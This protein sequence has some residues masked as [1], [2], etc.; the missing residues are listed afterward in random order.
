MSE[1]RLDPGLKLLYRIQSAAMSG[2]RVAA[3]QA[4][5]RS[6]AAEIVERLRTSAD[7]RTQPS[8]R[9]LLLLHY[10]GDERRLADLGFDMQARIGSVY[11]GVLDLEHL[12]ELAD[13]PGLVSAELSRPLRGLASGEPVSPGIYPGSFHASGSPLPSGIAAGTGVVVGLVD[14]G[15]DIRHRTFRNANGTTRIKYLLDLSNPGDVDGDGRLDGPDEF[16]GTLYTEAQINR[17]LASSNPPPTHDPTGHGTLA[18]S[19]AAGS[20]SKYPGFA[21]GAQLVVVKATRRDGTLDFESADLLSA[22]SFID[23]KAA[24]LHL[25]YVINMSLGTS[26]GPHDGKTAEEVAIDELVGPGIAGKA[27][28][29]AAGNSDQ[30]GTPSFRHFQGTAFTGLEV[31]HT[32]TIPRYATPTPGVGN[33]TALL[34]LWYEGSDRLTIRV[35]A[36]DGATTVTAAYGDFADTPTPFGQVFIGN[37]GGPDPRNGATEAVVLLYDESGMAPAAGDWTISVVGE[38]ISA[39]GIYHGWLVDGASLV[40]GVA[41]Y[42]SANADNNYLVA[43]PAAAENAI[44][45][46]SFARQDPASLFRTHWTDIKGTSHTDGGARTG[47][48][49]NFSSTGPTRDGRQK[50]DLTAPGELVIGAV[51]RDAFPGGSPSSIFLQ[52][53]PPSQPYALIIGNAPDRAFGLEQG[54]SF[55]A[56]VVTGLVARVLSVAPGLDAVQVRNVLLNSA[57]SDSFTGNVPSG[58]WGYGK[59]NLSLAAK[60]GATLP[61]SLRIAPD[62]LEPAVVG[63][64][65]SQI[66]SA[67]GGKAPFT[68]HA[69]GSLPAGIALTNGA[70]L[71]GIPKA[72]GSSRFTLQVT[73]SSSPP[74]TTSQAFAMVVAATVPLAVVTLNLP[75]GNLTSAYSTTLVAAGGT[76]PYSWS[77]RAG[78]LPPGVTLSLQGVLTGGPTVQ[79]RYFF[80]VSVA[81]A[82]GATVLRSLSLDVVDASEIAWQPVGLEDQYVR[83]IAVD[84]NDPNHVVAGVSTTERRYSLFDTFD[85]GRTWTKNSLHTGLSFNWATSLTIDPVT[86]ELWVTNA[87]QMPFKLDR[88]RHEWV[89]TLACNLPTQAPY[90]WMSDIGFDAAG[91]VLMLPYFADCPLMPSIDGFRGFLRSVNGGLTW[92]NVGFFPNAGTPDVPESRDQF[93]HLSVYAADP[94][95]LYASS[96]RGWQCC[97]EPVVEQMFRSDDGGATWAELPIGIATLSTP[98]V[99]QTNPAD[100]VRAPWNPDDYSSFHRVPWSPDYQGTSVIERSTDG[101]ATWTASQVPSHRVCRVARSASQPSVLLA[102]GID[103]L[104]KS[105]DSGAT[106]SAVPVQGGAPNFCEGG[107]VAIDPHDP[108]KVYAGLKN[109]RLASSTDGGSSWRISGQQL[110]QRLTNGVALSASRPTDLLTISAS[111]FVSRSNGVRWTESAYG[112]ND[113]YVRPER[114]QHPIISQAA[115]DT[116][117]FVGQSAY[118]LYRSQDRGVSWTKLTPAFGQPTIFSTSYSYQPN[119]L[120]IIADPFNSGILLARVLILQTVNG[121]L[122]ETESMWRSQDA[123]AT[124]TMV[125]EPDSSIVYLEISES[126]AFAHDAP[127]HVY[128]VGLHAL[129]ESTNYG[130]SWTPIGSYENSQGYTAVLVQPAPSDSRYIYVAVGPTVGAYDARAGNWSWTNLPYYTYLTSLAVD[131]HD[132]L[133]AYLG[134]S[135]ATYTDASGLHNANNNSGGIDKTTDGGRTWTRL[136]SFSQSLSVISLAVDPTT[137]GVLYAATLEDGVYKS[138]DDGGTWTKVDVYGV[139]SDVVNVAL[140]AP[141]NSNLLFAGTQGFGVQLSTDGGQT[142]IPRVNGLANLNVTCL[143][144]DPDTPEVLYAGTENGL[145]KTTDFGSSWVPTALAGGLITDISVDSGS[146]PRKIRITTYQLGVV[147]SEDRGETVSYRTDGLASPELTS[148]AVEQRSSGE[149]L[150]VTMR[151]GDGVAISDDLGVT[152]RSAAGSGLGN[153]NVNHLALEPGTQRAWIAT[154]GGIAVSGDG[155]ATWSN[156]SAGLPRGVPVTSL[157]FDPG[158][159]ELNASL[160]DSNAGGVFR[161]GNTTGTWSAFDQGLPDRR[162]R[163]LTND[164]GHAVAG[165]ARATT[166]YA[167]TAGSGLFT[168]D[169][170]SAGTGLRIATGSLPAATPD[171]HYAQPL[172]AVGGTPPYRWHVAGGALP[173]GLALD[174][175]AGNITGTPVTVG[176]FPFTVEVV[177]ATGS[178]ATADL[179]LLIQAVGGGH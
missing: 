105:Q 118:S 42:L 157:S 165:G 72:P 70:L 4:I 52:G 17:L 103:G 26:Y 16:G 1:R 109:G 31:R 68:W 80:T 131:P 55:S 155:G 10:E 76:P 57:Q 168:I 144:F 53:I 28:V 46:A 23:E 102:G 175:Q 37:L 83:L 2:N 39:T 65:Y 74:K 36:P 107:G 143:A 9:L 5:S 66:L 64:F 159:H 73:D 101:G 176:L 170:P 51:S 92:R 158:T 62:V 38:A 129:F 123:G 113:A 54:T 108:Q 126:I 33:N 81:D 45:V 84:P 67:S 69:G 22:L 139:L 106:W 60:A 171:I 162:V 27:V 100:I 142:F 40:G 12:T 146:H 89:P 85:A 20:D 152:W 93:G 145:F 119:I 43:R 116:F 151:G 120:S 49:S 134:R 58:T 47:N 6:K 35:T 164:G 88:A 90:T 167:S 94:R 77:L 21:P 61:S 110:L 136:T 154:D 111:P 149:R 13:L 133:T 121:K 95:Y 30:R 138:L 41:P 78:Q 147:I 97:T 18:L 153:R 179:S 34:D 141:G 7:E 59:A 115:P 91:N 19:I 112:V 173:P 124:W 125:K 98:Y 150:W 161:G 14:S 177:D 56:P 128:A 117:F 86:S 122:S 169:V 32:L 163:R 50:P 114:P 82:A 15:V 137:A 8:S 71:T 166:Y 63:Q 3:R 130:D 127:G 29:I 79:G 11:A 96:S 178:T 75:P 25:P 24:Q 44:A 148:I 156:A 160:L 135:Y 174:I 48:I 104:F 132:R 140:K 87:N 99:S 172:N